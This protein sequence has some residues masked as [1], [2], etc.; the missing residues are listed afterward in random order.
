MVPLLNLLLRERWRRSGVL[1]GWPA[2]LTS[3]VLL[4]VVAVGATPL[5]SRL[6]DS[7]SP[8]QIS[9]GVSRLVTA[10]IVMGVLFGKDLTW[11]TRL[12]KLTFFPLSF[13]RLYGLTLV[14]AF[15]SFPILL[16]LCVFEVSFYGRG[17]PGIGWF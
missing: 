12:D 9:D 13:D 3:F 1:Y 6:L 11:H 10:W 14:L 17:I 16:M 8:E 2:R 5:I 4:L 7:A 15:L